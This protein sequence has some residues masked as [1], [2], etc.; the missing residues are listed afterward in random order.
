MC[1]VE[2]WIFIL[3][4]PLISYVILGRGLVPPGGF[5]FFLLE[6][7]NQVPQ[8]GFQVWFSVQTIFSLQLSDKLTL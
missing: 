5:K 1:P 6:D 3:A 8:D 4:L 7:L 2:S